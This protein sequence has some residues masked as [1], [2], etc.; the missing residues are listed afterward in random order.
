ML[1]EVTLSNLYSSL[2]QMIF[3]LVMGNYNFKVLAF[4]TA[5]K[6]ITNS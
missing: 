6:K 1:I 5:G 2:L 3:P 4:N